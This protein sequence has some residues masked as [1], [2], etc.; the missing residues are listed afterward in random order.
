MILRKSILFF[1]GRSFLPQTIFCYVYG[2]NSVSF[3][4]ASVFFSFFFISFAPKD[5]DL[6]FDATLRRY[7]MRVNDYVNNHGQMSRSNGGAGGPSNGQQQGAR[8]AEVIDLADGADGAGV[9]TAEAARGKHMLPVP[10]SSSGGG[11]GV[12]G[13]AATGMRQPLVLPQE[14]NRADGREWA[15]QGSQQQQ[16]PAA[17]AVAMEAAPNH[18]APLAVAL[19]QTRQRRRSDSGQS[20]GSSFFQPSASSETGGGNGGGDGGGSAAVGG[21]AAQ[22]AQRQQQGHGGGGGGGGRQSSSP[23]GMLFSPNSGEPGAGEAV[24]MGPQGQQQQQQQVGQAAVP[25]E[26]SEGVQQVRHLVRVRQAMLGGGDAGLGGARG[27]DNNGGGVGGGGGVGVGADLAP[28]SGMWGSSPSEVTPG[29]PGFAG[30]PPAATAAPGAASTSDSGV[31]TP[32]RSAGSAG[33]DR[34]QINQ[35]SAAVSPRSTSGPPSAASPIDGAAP[36]GGVGGGRTAVTTA[37]TTAAAAAA[38]A[39]TAHGDSDGIGWDTT[40]SGGDGAVA[41]A[42]A[43]VA[44]DQEFWGEGNNGGEGDGAGA[45]NGSWQAAGGEQ[46]GLG[47]SSGRGGGG[48][49]PEAELPAHMNDDGEVGSGGAL[50]DDVWGFDSSGDGGDP[51]DEHASKRSRV[52]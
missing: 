31:V 49:M 13:L 23:R 16:K 1:S 3:S 14:H 50:T 36:G 45:E 41:A 52:E 19:Q 11:G 6:E 47:S 17:A 25:R 2:I 5:L 26:E 21:A 42:A 33:F 48:G 18:Q 43:A 40:S 51:V 34:H 7:V 35:V 24:P 8:S 29:S 10:D 39:A 30:A 28:A 22:G 27:D 37:V 20:F 32:A 4:G 15:E 9:S 46:L 44:L 12:A 38:V